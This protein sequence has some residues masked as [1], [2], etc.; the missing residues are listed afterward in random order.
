MRFS[1]RL[2]SFVVVSALAGAAACTPAKSGS[3]TMPSSGGGGAAPVAGAA[4]AVTRIGCGC[5]AV[6]GE[7]N[8]SVLADVARADTLY[9]R[10][11]FS[12]A[13]ALYAK[14][15]G[16]S[17]DAVLLYAQGMTQWQLGAT[18]DAKALLSA[19]ISAGGAFRDRAEVA[20][21]DIDAG[22][23]ASVGA[24]VTGAVA[25]AAGVG[26]AVGGA[27]GGVGGV[28]GGVAAKPKRIAG[29]A[30][31]L[32]GVV[33]V[34]AV[35]AVGIHAIAAGIKDDVELDAKFDLGLGLTGVV[36]GAT[37]V[38]IYGLTAASAT[39]AAAC[40]SRIVTLPPRKPVVAPMALNGG[41]GVTAVM[42]F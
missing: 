31:I 5:L 8:A 19:Y 37:A 35:G 14:A 24:A 23:P 30:G 21:R 4:G 17:K 10:A 38:Y 6:A 34:G 39:V 26:G 13:L 27:V 28:V 16:I 33:A 20:L 25:G 1:A 22:V 11:D 12:G 40:A 3:S 9:A 42:S 2:Y 36:V 29:A 32:L 7:V 41:G 18:G 15:H